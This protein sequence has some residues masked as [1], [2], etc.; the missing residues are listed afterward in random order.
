[1]ENNYSV[2]VLDNLSSESKNNLQNSNLL[3]LYQVNI[4][5]DDLEDIFKTEKP[6]YVVHLAA[7]TSVN[8][9]ISNTYFDF[10]FRYFF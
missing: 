10:N 3:K 9:S 5:K 7:Q 4:K 6:D 1:M 2:V 8:Y